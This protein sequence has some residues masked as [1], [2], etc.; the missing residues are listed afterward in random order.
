MCQQFLLCGFWCFDML[1]SIHC[2]MCK[3]VR[4]MMDAGRKHQEA[5]CGVLPV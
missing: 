4:L 2:S 1:L 5:A 3:G